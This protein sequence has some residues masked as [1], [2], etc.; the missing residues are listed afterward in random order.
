[1]VCRCPHATDLAMT[2]RGRRSRRDVGLR[3]C[4]DLERAWRLRGSCG[5]WR[6]R[7]VGQ[8]AMCLRIDGEPK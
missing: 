6:G 7:R 4:A 3:A 1:M 2:S 8:D 5:I